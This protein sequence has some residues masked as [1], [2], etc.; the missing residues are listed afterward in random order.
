MR[1]KTL[2]IL[3]VLGL[4]Y[5]ALALAADGGSKSKDEEA[6]KAEAK[7]QTTCPVSGEKI[8]KAVHADHQGK[9]VY[10]CCADCVEPFRKDPD[11][12]IQKLEGAGV[13]LE[14]VC[15][16]GEVKGSEACKKACSAKKKAAPRAKTPSCCNSCA[17]C[18]GCAGCGKKR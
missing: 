13:V 3:L 9:R 10:F 7:F 1:C 16:C 18:P 12:Y 6:K 14:R 11:K 15:A 5:P 2:S 4:A 17:G 8:N